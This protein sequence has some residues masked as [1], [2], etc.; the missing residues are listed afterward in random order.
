MDITVH[1]VLEN[2]QV[3]ELHAANGGA[4]GGTQV[5]QNFIQLMRRVL[6]EKFIDKYMEDCPQQWLALMTNFEKVKKSAKP[7]G[8]SKLVIPLS[9]S[10]GHKHQEVVGT[11]IESV[12]LKSVPLGV[13][14]AN[15]SL[16]IKEQAIMELFE[17]V[18]REILQHIESLLRL[19][20][21]TNCQYFLLV[22]GFGECVF[23]Q[24]A[25]EDA[26][27]RRVCLLVP[28]EAQMSVIKGA[29]LFGHQPA[30]IK[31]RIAKN[32]YGIEI[33]KT[34][35]EG[36]HDRSKAAIFDGI[37]KCCE[38]FDPFVQM[39]VEVETGKTE[40]LTYYPSTKSQT[41]VSIHVY[42][43]DE[44]SPKEK[45]VYTDTT[46]MQ[47]MGKFNVDMP[48]TRGG[49]NRPIKLDIEYGGTE[50]H[51]DATDVTSG[52]KAK[53]SIDFLTG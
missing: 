44:K 9:W 30:A 33:C 49:R 25:I 52:S 39:G 22:G 4:W 34:F 19:P 45:L 7:D 6:G 21:V 11:G 5:D 28:N 29:V 46:G 32:T 12:I 40:T 3:K 1:E 2:N 10:M 50:I 47:S 20:E 35:K 36:I 15:G 38:I 42:A 37:L 48:D 31:S 53:A 23:L 18:I 17:P 14:F 8:S 24:K 16:I 27:G 41:R 43:I 26:F 51:I 13:S